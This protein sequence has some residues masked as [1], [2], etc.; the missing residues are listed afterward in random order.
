MPGSVPGRHVGKAFRGEDGSESKHGIVAQ[1]EKETRENRAS[2]G[3]G[4][5]K[6]NADDSK[7]ANEAPRIAELRRGHQPKERACYQYAGE[8]PCPGSARK[9]HSE[10][11]EYCRWNARQDTIKVAPLNVFLHHLRDPHRDVQ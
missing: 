3:A 11:L 5:S 7:Q 10:K 1:V 8:H 9:F 6:N 4:K 2:P